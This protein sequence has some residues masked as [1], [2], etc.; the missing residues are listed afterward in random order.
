[1]KIFGY[2]SL[3][4]SRFEVMTFF[5]PPTW[6]DRSK[7]RIELWNNEN[8]GIIII[9]KFHP[10]ETKKGDNEIGWEHIGPPNKI[11]SPLIH[12][13]LYNLRQINRHDIKMSIL[14]KITFAFI[15]YQVR[16]KS[17]QQNSPIYLSALVKT[18][19]N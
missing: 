19:N 2:C 4:E 9:S 18:K 12:F 13:W 7:P 6:T 8:L 14:L 11:E 16:Y 5:S 10:S 3:Q 17:L 1:M 15:K